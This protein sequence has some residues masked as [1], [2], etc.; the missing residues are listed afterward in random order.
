MEVS[1]KIEMVFVCCYFNP[2]NYLSKYINFLIFY[3]E[4]RKNS[5]VDLLVVESYNNNSKYRIRTNVD[6]LISVKSESILWE[7]EAL[8][9][10]GINK[11]KT[12]Y[13]YVG[14]VDADVFFVSKN[15]EQEILSQLKDNN[16]V[17]ICKIIHQQKSHENLDS[18]KTYSMCHYARKSDDM[19][20]IYLSRL[21]EP[22]YGCVYNSSIF[23]NTK[24]PLYDKAIMGSGD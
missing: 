5:N 4:F 13:K 20:S 2:C 3:Q 22:G 17:Q 18:D 10:I 19:E 6:N 1:E 8:L 24:T 14:W 12:K 9:N 16:I 15:W 21:G 7:K 23:K 11:T